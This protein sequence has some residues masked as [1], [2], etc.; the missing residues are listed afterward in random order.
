MSITVKTIADSVCAGSGIRITT[1]AA[2]YPRMVHAELMTHRVFSRNASS[3][4]AIPVHKMIEEVLV[5]PA[6]PSR[7]GANQRGMQDKGGDHDTPV[8]F[9]GTVVQTMFSSD[10]VFDEYTARD[11]WL[12]ARDRAVEVAL[13]FDE[14]GYHKQVVNRL[15]EPFAHITVVITSTDWAN[16]YG[17]RCHED[18]DPTMR[19]LA[20]AMK[21]E[22]DRSV[23]K[24][25]LPKQWHLPF[26]H[27]GERDMFTLEETLMMSSARCA[28]V[29]YRNHDNVPPTLMEDVDLY[30]RLVRADLV[31]ASPTEHQARP[32]PAGF[33][34]HLWGNFR[35]FVQHRKTIQ[36]EAIY[37]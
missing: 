34:E 32:D 26:V 15:L 12:L 4:R 7:F 17:L 25:L 16:F 3:S 9:G 28:R 22:H 14:A 2:R 27:D 30:N 29:S 20:E 24:T 36:K 6:I 18:A 37:D 23:P 10:L 5:D 33:E 1:L 31:H 13:A 21:E 8:K 11:A 35:G 19:E